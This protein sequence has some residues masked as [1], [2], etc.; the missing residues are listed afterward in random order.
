ML[1]KENLLIVLLSLA[2]AFLFF[3]IVFP[4][5]LGFSPDSMF[6]LEG[7]E[8]ILHGKGF[9]KQN[10]DLINHWPP[11]YSLLLA[12]VSLV[13]RQ[14]LFFSGI[15]LHAILIFCQSFLFYK[16]LK[17]LE[18]RQ[19]LC[20]FGVVILMFSA[21]TKVFLW[22]L[23]EGLF[24][25]LLLTCIYLLIKWIKS[26]NGLY[27]YFAGIITGLFML[28]RHAGLSFAMAFSL[29][30]LLSSRG[31]FSARIYE[32]GRFLVP[33]VVIFFPWFFYAK[34]GDSQPISHFASIFFNWKKIEMGKNVIKYWFVGNYISAKIA[35]WIIALFLFQILFNYRKIRVSFLNFLNKNR[36]VL[37]LIFVSVT[38]YLLFLLFANFYYND[39]V[40]FD[41][42]LLF[43]VFPLLI[44]NILLLLEYGAASKLRSTSSILV[45]FLVM[46][47][48]I[49][50]IP[51]YTDFYLNGLGFMQ[52][53]WKKSSLIRYVSKE[54][55]RIY[56]TNAPEIIKLH[57]NNGSNLLPSD[58]RKKELQIIKRKVKQGSAQ[59]LILKSF[60]WREY[61][62]KEE[63]IIR[64]F[65]NFSTIYFDDGL[66]IK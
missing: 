48:L 12:L 53:K 57:T 27:L 32:L 29:S 10:G 16:I 42:R 59:I 11:L 54:E 62:M 20:V 65:K 47:S 37:L 8:N 1:L 45:I 30:I 44:M 23:S 13:I 60:P 51:V 55:G 3:Q 43:P 33:A 7:A 2:A 15:I 61:I 63:D 25:V 5:N 9:T 14:D 34:S 58:S 26:K 40:P 66:I 28:T 19:W 50:A 36:S 18:V 4:N 38:T 22:F 41:N 24:S 64:E 21:P 31:N 17:I 46:S 52:R 35:P 49:S 6:Y 39:Q 56:Y